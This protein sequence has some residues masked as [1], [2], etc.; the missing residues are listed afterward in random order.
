MSEFGGREKHFVWMQSFLAKLSF[1]R[2]HFY[3]SERLE[4][5][6]PAK[7]TTAQIGIAVL[8]NHC[9]NTSDLNTHSGSVKALYFW[10][11]TDI[12]ACK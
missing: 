5:P 3:L 10:F 8:A 9:Q 1:C 2:Y 7:T 6:L 11:H 12:F 4:S